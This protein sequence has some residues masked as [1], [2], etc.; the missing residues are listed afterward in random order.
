LTLLACALS[1]AASAQVI[2]NE[3]HYH[4]IELP[5]FNASGNPVF[6]GTATPGGFHGRRP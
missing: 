2:I 5:A 4:P 3:V 1:V 6:Q